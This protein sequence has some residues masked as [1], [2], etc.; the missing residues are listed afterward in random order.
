MIG[1]RRAGVEHFLKEHREWEEVSAIEEGEPV[2]IVRGGR[3]E[4]VSS[5]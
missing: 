1:K 4:P 2:S 5:G 3:A